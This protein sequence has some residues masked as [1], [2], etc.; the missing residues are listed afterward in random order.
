MREP[1]F[2][3]YLISD[4][5]QASH[6][7]VY[8]SQILVQIAIMII[9]TLLY[10]ILAMISFG[11]FAI[12]FAPLLMILYAIDFAWGLTSILNVFVGAIS[13]NISNQNVAY[14]LQKYTNVQAFIIYVFS[15]IKNGKYTS[16]LDE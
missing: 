16:P 11:M 10:L 8:A 2:V 6:K 3:D 4:L 12:L 1:K 13:S 7:S 5:P 15:M 9:I 14:N